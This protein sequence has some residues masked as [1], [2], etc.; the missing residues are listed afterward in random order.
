MKQ[1]TF[2]LTSLMLSSFIC[3]GQSNNHPS[4]VQLKILETDV[5][6]GISGQL[7]PID[8][9]LDSSGNLIIIGEFNG[10]ID[11]DPSADTYILNAQPSP[12]P[13]QNPLHNR[14]TYIAKY[15]ASGS[16]IWAYKLG[17]DSNIVKATSLNIDAHN[18]INITGIF[19]Y[20][21]D[22]D[23]WDST[24]ILSSPNAFKTYVASYRSNGR[25]NWVNTID[26]GN[27]GQATPRDIAF[28]TDGR[29]VVAG[30]F[31]GQ[32]IFPT[33]S[34]I[35]ALSNNGPTNS[36]LAEL[37]T[38]G[39]WVSARHI[40]NPTRI[41]SVQ[42]IVIDSNNN[43]VCDIRET[44]P[45][46]PL[47]YSL[48]I[49]KYYNNSYGFTDIIKLVPDNY[50]TALTL[51]AMN[52]DQHDAVYFGGR[53]KVR[54]FVNGALFL[55]PSSPNGYDSYIIKINAFNNVVWKKTLIPKETLDYVPTL[56]INNLEV[57]HAN[58]LMIT[59]GIRGV[60][61]IGGN[62]T[63]S[64]NNPAHYT[65]YIMKFNQSGNPVWAFP[66]QGNSSSSSISTTSLILNNDSF[67]VYGELFS[68]T[69]FD[70]HPFNS[71]NTDVVYNDPDIFMVKYEDVTIDS[72]K[73]A[74]HTTLN[75]YEIYPTVV[76]NY[77]T[78]KKLSNSTDTDFL[79]VYDINGKLQLHTEIASDEL[80]KNIQLNSLSGGLYIL[81]IKNKKGSLIQT[82]KLVKK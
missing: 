52:I 39:N 17:D 36:F 31:R 40:I 9:G 51:G 11:M 34:A 56:S 82:A 27:S 23:L 24:N 16:L 62:T 28:K 74:F 59:G 61:N 22:F 4:L 41:F 78:I 65:A 63:F 25:L 8:S 45:G 57:D 10:S 80:N 58:R 2:L 12:P 18:N 64:G 54:V 1:I 14:S 66:F 19:R 30:T 55:N 53:F 21:V 50:N 72:L 32:I 20:T 13:N 76:E 60:Y 71:T 7:N 47:L 37:N 68:L 44:H 46:S 79:E 3:L 48:T 35:L 43:I 38:K 42:S 29:I 81:K 15:T 49:R 67:Y 6:S 70:F 33:N 77:I 69:D 26:L 75:E 5:N 73:E